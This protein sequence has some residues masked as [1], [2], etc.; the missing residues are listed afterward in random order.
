MG[1]PFVQDHPA[2]PSLCFLGG[3]LRFQEV[4]EGLLGSR[5]GQSSTESLQWGIVTILAFSFFPFPNHR[6][7][8]RIL[9]P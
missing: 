5:V 9:N 2:I 3:L 6:K 7:G 8:S 1:F 4:P